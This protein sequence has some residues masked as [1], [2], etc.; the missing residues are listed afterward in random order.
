MNEVIRDM[1]PLQRQGWSIQLRVVDVARYFL[2][3]LSFDFG[4]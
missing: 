4:R 1:S 3:R 2:M